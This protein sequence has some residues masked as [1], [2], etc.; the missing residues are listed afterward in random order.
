MSKAFTKESDGDGDDELEG[1][2]ALPPGTKNYI[3]PEGFQR[4]QDELKH[5]RRVERPKVVETV[6][7]A[8]GNGDRSENGDYI[9]GK[10]RLRE[11]DRRMRFLTKRLEIAEIVDPAQQKR[12]DQVFFGATVT[13]ADA[14]DRE[15]TIRIVGI[16]EA[17]HDRGE[18]SWISPVARAFL[19]ARE[20]D[21]VEVRTPG[22]VESL[23]I[24]KIDYDE[25]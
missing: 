3:T 6:A 18:V 2:P 9:Y 17:R 22:G 10:K 25:S 16:D 21:V 13:Y 1:A 23:E 7:W 5:L 8:A 14:E 19:K 11:I 20:G 24:V 4:L 15:R 12:R